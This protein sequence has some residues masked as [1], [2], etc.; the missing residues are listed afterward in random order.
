MLITVSIIIALLVA[1]NV[2]LLIF[3]CNKISDYKI[4]ENKR[5]QMVI[6]TTTKQSQQSYYAATGS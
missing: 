2:L 3:S 5:I 1:I 4:D 6:E